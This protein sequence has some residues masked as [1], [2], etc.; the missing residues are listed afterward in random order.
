M[1]AGPQDPDA[2]LVKRIAQG[3]QEAARA[4][5]DRHLARMT[6]L[7]RRMLGD[8][9]E[10]EDVAQDVFLRVW[11]HAGLWR[12]GAAKFETWMMRVAINL[13]YDRMRRRREIAT[14]APPERED[15][16]PTGFDVV[17]ARDV[18]TAVEAAMASLPPRQRAAVTLCHYQEMTNI[19][20][21]QAL[22]VSV[23]ALESLLSRARRALR[24]AL[25]GE[26]GALL[27]KMDGG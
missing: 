15:D 14:D 6:T 13:C 17:H 16:A 11:R 22:E 19:E 5:V 1:T 2:G 26:A 12:P 24:A 27:E 23:E 4:L 3:D 10:A 8:A 25:K 9:A 18:A 20:A 21:A 7:A